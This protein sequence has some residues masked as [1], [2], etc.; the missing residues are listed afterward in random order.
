M[1]HLFYRLT[2]EFIG[3]FFYT[4]FVLG[5]HMT[6]EDG[7]T[8]YIFALS[9]GVSFI[10]STLIYCTGHVSGGHLNPAVS[11]AF[12]SASQAEFSPLD[13]FCYIFIQF[14]GAVSA[15]LALCLMI[16]ES[17]DRSFK[18]GANYVESG[19]GM[20]NTFIAEMLMTFLI[21][22]VVF[23]TALNDQTKAQLT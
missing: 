22:H 10:T 20:G 23:N 17:Q 2:G 14:A 16:P 6:L 18:F 15:A 5:L 21:C 4:F 11:L 9:L 19:F 3:T 7:T 8:D 1:Q 12:L 13:C